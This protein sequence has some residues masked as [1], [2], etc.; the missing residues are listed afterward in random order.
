MSS[1]TSTDVEQPAI[2]LTGLEK[3]FTENDTALN[4]LLPT[5]KVKQVRAVDGVDLTVP[6]GE[7]VGLVG[8]SGCGKSTLARTLLRL[9]EPTGGSVHIEDEEVTDLSTQELKELRGTAQ[10]IFQDP[11]SSLNPRY[12]VKETLVEPMKVHGIGES[13]ADRDKRARQLLDRVGLGDEHLE[14]YPHEFSGGQRQR[15]AIARALSV[16]PDVIVADEPV[17][18]LDVSVQAQIL[19]LL[20]E[21]KEEMDLTML[22]ISHD[23]SVVRQICDRVAV[24]YLGK[25]VEEAPTDR[26][27]ENPQHPY[28]EV[29]VSS[30]PTPDPTVERNRMRLEGSVPTPIDPPSGCR[31]HPRCPKVIPPDRWSG[32]QSA[33][34][35]VLQ[36]KHRVSNGEVAPD[37]MR[38]QLQ[39]ETDG[40]VS[41]DDVV[42][43]LYKEHILAPEVAQAEDVS[44]PPEHDEEV[45][46]AL[47]RVVN[48]NRSEAIEFLDERFPTVCERES[49]ERVGVA[50]DHHAVC[51]LNESGQSCHGLASSETA[52]R[53][54]DS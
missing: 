36:L 40:S 45:R 29:L 35:R 22:F 14:R 28:T 15:V 5:R 18:A 51:H 43:E 19:N 52:M 48:G 25:I 31:F 6:E 32:G 9:L 1:D 33:W 3:Y 53:G 7:T 30:I 10:M 24:M 26:L 20:K 11:F 50:A 42:E 54:R 23:L 47:E 17:S 16:E 2:E 13:A 39:E 46:T 44:L 34:R 27:Y 49:P 38:E 41:D 12:T 37:A 21:L 4:R 8:E